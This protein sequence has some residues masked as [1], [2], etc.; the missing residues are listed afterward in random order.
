MTKITESEIEEFAI[1][2]LE[3]QGYRY[4]YGPDISPEGNNSLRNGFDEVILEEQLKSAI[5][6]INPGISEEAEVDALH[7]VKSRNFADP[8]S[9]NEDFHKI[10]TEGVNVVIKTGKSSSSGYISF[11]A[12]RKALN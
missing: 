6:R 3:K 11:I 8:I 4:M 2:L 7:R 5:R 1:N 9:G 12:V 10:L